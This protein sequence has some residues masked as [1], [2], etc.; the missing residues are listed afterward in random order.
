MRRR[1]SRSSLVAPLLGASLAL[2]ACEAASSGSASGADA[3]IPVWTLAEQPRVDIGGASADGPAMFFGAM[4]ATRLSDGRI[5]VGDGGSS[6]LRIFGPDG[7]HLR[8]TG[9]KGSGPGEFSYLTWVGRF[10]GDSILAYDESTRRLAAYGP[11]GDL[12]GTVSLSLPDTPRFPVMVGVFEDGRLLARPGFDRRFGRGERRDTVPFLIYARTGERADTIV[13]HPGTER[14]F[15]ATPE[16][17]TQ[18][19]VGFGRDAFAAVAG[20]LAVIGSSD[21][22]EVGLFD[23]AGRLVQ[24]LRA[25]V[26]ATPVAEADVVAWRARLASQV[27]GPL[28]EQRRRQLADIPHRPTYPAF[29]GL[30]VSAAGDY[31]LREYPRAGDLDAPA[32]WVV[33]GRDGTPRARVTTPAR[34]R[35]LEVGADWVLGHWS[36]SEDVSHLQLY[37]LRR[38]R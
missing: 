25:D 37:D 2:G 17:A 38:D 21:R 34:F 7:R 22:H 4:S 24:R 15:V 6:E 26:P 18:W 29:A 20:D 27:R 30:A 32:R 1:R 11:S 23:A 9:G 14:F 36:D 3:P 16:W 33:Y 35:L 31:W 28:V 8:T 19:E 5:V 13:T 10:A 12:A